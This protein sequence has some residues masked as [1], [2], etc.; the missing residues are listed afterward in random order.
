MTKHLT[1]AAAAAAAL[2]LSAC[3]GDDEP[4][5]TK[6]ASAAV[7]EATLDRGEFGEPVKVAGGITH[8]AD[9]T[10]DRATG[11]IYVSWAADKPKPKGRTF[12]PQDIWVAHSDDGGAT[13]S[14]PVRANSLAGT[15]NAGFNTQ[16]RIAATGDDRLL[17]SWPLMNDDHSKMNAMVSLSADGGKTFPKEKPV[18]AADGPKTTE[19]YHALATYGKNVYASYLDY[20]DLVNPAM[21]TGLNLVHSS[22]GGKTWSP[23]TRGEVSSCECCDTA[24]AVDSQGTVFYAYRN[25]DLTTKNNQVRDSAVIRS[26]DHGKTWSDPVELG[27]DDWVFNGCPE[28]GPEITVDGEDDVHGVYWTG[29]EG[30]QG[31]YYTWSTD[32]GQSFADPLR[33][34]VDEFY[35]PAYMDVA[36]DGEKTAWI[37]WDDRRTKDR[38]V[39]LAR[40]R[41]GKVEVVDG[42]LGA[43]ITPA[44]DSDGSMV[45]LT[46]SDDEGLHV[47]TRG[48]PGRDGYGS[49]PGD[50]D[51]GQEDGEGHDGH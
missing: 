21:P 45:A 51:S 8:D 46:W 24:L 4:E 7:P 33:V 40:A 1:L 27:D 3:G 9:I 34:A 28:A 12:T 48:E 6:P 47:M 41:D 49:G 11:R 32:G 38:Q 25:K 15:V 42:G 17:A 20:R 31:V 43:G 39:H 37:V 19:L 13:F 23:S 26:Y 5:R 16:T 14:K 30:R 35:P 36:V 29:K 2:T 22:D 10:I 44:I 50:E 18:S